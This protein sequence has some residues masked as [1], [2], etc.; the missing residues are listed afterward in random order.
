MASMVSFTQGIENNTA[1]RFSEKFFI[2]GFIGMMGLF[3]LL[4]IYDLCVWIKTKIKGEKKKVPKT[5]DSV[6][7]P[8]NRSGVI[9]L[10]DNNATRIGIELEEEINADEL[11]P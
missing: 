2:F 4:M 5:Q 11:G 7:E 10:K 8:S 3:I 9:L 1:R 6:I